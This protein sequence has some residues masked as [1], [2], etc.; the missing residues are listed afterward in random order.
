[1][2]RPYRLLRAFSGGRALNKE[3]DVGAV[4]R[5]AVGPDWTNPVVE[6]LSFHPHLGR[7]P[8]RPMGVD[9]KSIAKASK[10]RILHLPPC[11]ERA[12]D[13]RKRRSG[14]LSYTWWGYRKLPC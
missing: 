1:M 12:S 11:A 10:V 5:G 9:C 14:A 8:E 7:L 3:R 13:Q 2:R 4:W 6:L